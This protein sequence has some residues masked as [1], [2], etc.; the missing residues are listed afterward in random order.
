MSIITRIRK[1]DSEV[2]NEL[3]QQNN[4]KF[5]KTAKAILKNDDDVY[6]AI[7]NALISMY[8]NIGTLKDEKYFTTWGVR[9]V[10]N[11]CYDLLR[12][13]KVVNMISYEN[14]INDATY[15]K[16][17]LDLYGIEKALSYLEK[18]LYLIVILYYYDDLKIKE[19]AKI[20]DLPEGTVK[21]KLLRAR[22]ILKEKLGKEEL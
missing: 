21:Y 20:V 3:I 1:G 13:N 14:S 22:N 9:I 11:K 10:V 18:D 2:F 17:D 6:D 16:Y 8:Q 19:I 15:D 7:Q 12:K 5:Y 4:L